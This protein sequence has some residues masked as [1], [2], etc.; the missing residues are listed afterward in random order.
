MRGG[1][2]I[3]LLAFVLLAGVIPFLALTGCGRRGPPVPP[4]SQVPAAVGALRAEPSDSG[5][6]VTWNRPTRNEDGSPLED[7]REFRLYRAVG[8]ASPREAGA[9]PVFS[10]LATIRAEQP[11]NAAVLDGQ[12]AFRDDGGG[13]GLLPG[14]R[15]TYRVQGVNR[16]GEAGAPSPEVSVDFALAPPPPVALAAS[17]GDGMVTLTWQAPQASPLTGTPPVR[18]YN[19]YRSLRPGVY[20][21]QPINAGPVVETQFRDAG[22][23]NGTSYYYMVRSVG[24]E[25]PPWRESDNSSEVSATPEDL[26]PPSPPQGLVA[27]PSQGLVALSWNANPEPD[28]LGYLVYRREPPAVSAGRLTESPVLGTTFTDRTA[29]SGATY[30][31]SVTAVDRSPRRN[32][33]AMSAELSVTV[34]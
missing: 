14:V 22:V 1:A 31:Y 13:G 30:M 20:P 23:Q 33:S 24:I 19:V 16:R 29:R 28:L 4:R 10:L 17:G 15:Y 12:Y 11:D 32:E 5:I 7:L 18:G 26:T 21:S 34:P 3:A 2:P 9:R 25:R 27:I 8:A 6:V